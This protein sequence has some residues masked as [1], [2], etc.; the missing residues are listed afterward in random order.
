[1]DVSASEVVLTLGASAVSGRASV[2]WGVPRVRVA[3]DLAGERVDVAPFLGAEPSTDRTPAEVLVELLE[4]VATGVDG[5]VRASASELVGLPVAVH[6]VQLEGRSAG[7]AVALRAQGTLSGTRATATL[8]YDARKPQRVLAARLEGGAASSARLP[9]WARP[10]RVAGTT[11]AI[12]GQAR[13]QGASPR[14]VVASLQVSLEARDLRWT[15]T[16]RGAEPLS[17]RFDSIR[18][19]VQGTRASS[20][21][22]AGKLG[23]AACT[24]RVSGGALA[25]LLEGAQWPVQLAGAC[26]GARLNAK[27]RIALAARHVA[28]ELAFD[29]MASRIGPIATAFGVSP[30]APHAFAARGTLAVDEKLAR[31]KL[32]SVRLGRTAGSGEAA[33]PLGREGTPSVHLALA[34]LDIAELNSLADAPPTPSDPLD[35]EVLRGKKRL[36]DADFRITADRVALAGETLRRMH[37]SGAM[38]GGRVPPVAFGFEWNGAPVAGEFGADFSG[39]MP[40]VEFHVEAQ[41]AD[42]GPLIARSGQKGVGL[43]AGALSLHV[44][45]EGARLGELLAAATLD[46]SIERGRLEFRRA[47]TPGL[48]RQAD[49]TATLKAAPGQPA[50]LA[51]RGTIG[52]EPFELAGDSPTLAGLARAGAPVPGTVRA[53]VGDMRF[54]ASGTFGRDGTGAAQLDLSGPRLDRLGKLAGVDLPEIGP[55]AARAKVVFATDAV[56]ASDLDVSFGKSRVLGKA[57]FQVRRTGRA[58]HSAALRAPALHLEDLGAARWLH[59]PPAVRGGAA[60]EA[61]VAEREAAR[62]A[63][64]LEWLRA[65][66]VDAAIDVDGLHGGAERIASGRLRASLAAGRLRIEL[67]D[68]KTAG[69]VIEADL[70]VDASGAQPKL[71]ARARVDGLDF[72][73]LARALDPATKLGGRVDL[74]AD[75]A[76]QGPPERVLTALTG[77]IDTAMFPHDLS[78]KALAFWGTGL[79]SAMLR[80]VDP[81]ERSEVECAAASLDVADGVASTSALFVDTSRVRIVG[82]VDAN[83]VTHKL[84]GRL[85][86]VSEQPE[87]FTVAPTLMLGGTME[88]PRVSVAPEN[89]VFAPVRFAT[90]LARFA[91]DFVRA[92]GR[93]SE[94]K[95]GC[96]EAYER[97]RALRPAFGRPK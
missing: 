46:A 28:A 84:S 66:D 8:D 71:A 24:L 12:R 93:L 14:A 3:A 96:R 18:V 86:A 25:P 45:S 30:N 35:R 49:F 15:T 74:V 22:I 91:L 97:A 36:P 63:R 34:T 5:E 57:E 61:S 85:Y 51:A 29:A 60:P 16:G 62:M 13:G 27:G 94:G 11:G 6:A 47:P 69:G 64:V 20:V 75:L 68:A 33:L 54:H 9:R 72:G 79:L 92:K 89:I 58:S 44:R 59:G 95:V 83:L 10:D 65:T 32:A 7:A 88:S 82:Q 67:Q 19:A 42:L 77:T 26:P 90:P 39:A 70:R 52:G 31:V 23:D 38:R 76:A 1:V 48:P 53:T 37:V 40:R 78:S 87:L 43:R 56:R 17:G 2:G 73:P 81:D 55:Y 50:A 21:E 80:T 41:N 4:R